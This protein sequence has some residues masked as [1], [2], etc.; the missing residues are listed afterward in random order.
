[1]KN[2]HF[3][4]LIWLCN[5]NLGNHIK[6]ESINR[7]EGPV[8]QEKFERLKVNDVILSSETFSRWQSLFV[9]FDKARNLIIAKH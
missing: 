7:L 1:M 2:Q 8:M 5:E 3:L 6:T 9:L 4:E